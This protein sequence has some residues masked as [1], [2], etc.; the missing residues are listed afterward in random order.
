MNTAEEVYD[1]DKDD[2][3]LFLINKEGGCCEKV[4]VCGG[5]RLC[6]EGCG[7][8]G[9]VVV[10]VSMREPMCEKCMKGEMEMSGH[11]KWTG[12]CTMWFIFDR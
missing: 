8:N 5:S 11:V 10:M 1:E 6:C 9:C 2:A 7:C 4:W 3:T 12:M